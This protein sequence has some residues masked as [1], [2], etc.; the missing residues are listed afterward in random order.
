MTGGLAADTLIGGDGA[1]SMN[2]GDGADT[3]SGGEG[4][5]KVL[6]GAG[7]DELIG[8]AGNDILDGGAGFNCAEYGTETTNLSINL[9]T[10]VATGRDADGTAAIGRDSLLSIQEVCSGSGNDSLVAADTASQLEGGGGNDTMTGGLAADTLVG[11]TGDDTFV[12][13]FINDVIT[14]LLNGGSDTVISSI[15][16]A[17]LANNVEN[18]TLTGTAAINATGN[19]LANTLVGNAGNNK[20]DGGQGMDIL[21][22]GGGA[23]LIFGGIDT[24]KDVFRFNAVSD[25]TTTARDK[26]YN[27]LSGTDKL[28]FS[29]IDANN[30]LNGDQAFS[31]NSIGKVPSNYSIWV[32]A[33][34]VDLIISADTDGNASTIEFQVQLVGITQIYMAD[35]VL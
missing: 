19:A 20:L 9:K 30:L 6:G 33:S 14:E 34:G 12:V 15:T 4:A 29:G 8:G 18:L 32:M 24:V 7:D 22:G 3:I 31:N 10:R 23:D 16:Q 27:F 25:S 11:G 26:I 2:G 13:N 5:D 21:A 28:D 35:V 1:D 17:V